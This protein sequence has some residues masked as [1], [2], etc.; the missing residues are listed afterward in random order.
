[1]LNTCEKNIDWIRR[2]FREYMKLEDRLLEG[3]VEE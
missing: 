3:E 2:M 1:M